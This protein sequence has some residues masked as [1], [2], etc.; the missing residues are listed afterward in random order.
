[1]TLSL[2]RGMGTE[3]ESKDPGAA[4]SAMPHQGVLPECLE[5]TLPRSGY[6]LPPSRSFTCLVTQATFSKAKDIKDI[7]AG[8]D[9]G[10]RPPGPEPGHGRF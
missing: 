3:E 4:S 10:S 2:R 8:L 9:S 7:G 1:M 5:K 6:D